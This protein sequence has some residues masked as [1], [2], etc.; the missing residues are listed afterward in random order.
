MRSTRLAHLVLTKWRKVLT[1]EEMFLLKEY[2]E[3]MEKPDP[4]DPFPEMTLTTNLEGP[5]GKL[6]DKT[7]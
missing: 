7:F 4:E 3:G 5:S 1:E 2:G 6:L